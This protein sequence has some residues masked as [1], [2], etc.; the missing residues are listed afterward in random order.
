MIKFIIRRA[1][2]LIPLFF[3]AVIISFLIMRA[4]PGGPQQA[5]AGIKS[6]SQE[7][8]EAWLRAWCLQATHAT[9]PLPTQV[10]NMLIEFGGWVGVLNC[11]NTGVQAL[12][13]RA[14]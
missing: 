10:G 9:D 1:I 13:I 8:R 2:G 12:W 3:G 11:N 7:D 14:T 6:L 5:L 4:A